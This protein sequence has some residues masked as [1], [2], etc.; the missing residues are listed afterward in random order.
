[1][2]RAAGHLGRVDH[3]GFDQV[4]VVAGRFARDPRDQKLK[5]Q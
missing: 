2:Q 3:A 5:R 1:L 4:F